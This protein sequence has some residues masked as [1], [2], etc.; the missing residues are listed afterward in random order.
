MFASSLLPLMVLPLW[1]YIAYAITHTI[2]EL[3]HN[4]HIQER[5]FCELENK[6]GSIDRG[7]LDTYY[8]ESLTWTLLPRDHCE[9]ILHLFG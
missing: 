3:T 2:Y 8:A 1:Y 6:L 4:A 7:N 9:S 5:L